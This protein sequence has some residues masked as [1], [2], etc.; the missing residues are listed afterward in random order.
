MHW[1]DGLRAESL[2]LPDRGLNFGDGLFETMLFAQERVFYQDLHLSRLHKG[3][4]ALGFP[5]CMASVQAQLSSV[6]E[7]LKSIQATQYAL[8]LTLT[9]GDGPRGYA[10]GTAC[11]P[12]V[13][14]STADLEQGWQVQPPAAAAGIAKMRWSHQPQLAGL[15]HL[16]RLEQVLAARQ[17]M[18]ENI[19]ELIM[20]DEHSSAISTVS[21]N[22]FAVING[23]LVTPELSKCGIE[24]TRRRLILDRWAREIGVDTRE[25]NMTV[26][27]LQES[28]EMF[29]CNT[30]VGLRPISSFGSSAWSNYPIC[31][32]LHQVYCGEN[33]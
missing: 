22:L 20:L 4:E 30:L 17:R 13:I 18:N 11:T 32:A 15:K 1:V 31:E 33:K 19:D 24:G 16:N 27:E 7:Q 26:Q 9:R 3:I 25:A 23:V 29:F 8:R 6:A 10:P 21:G 12:R 5:D 28:T 2:P 14:I